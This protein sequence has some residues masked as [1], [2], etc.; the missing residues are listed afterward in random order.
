MLQVL[1]VVLLAEA[2]GVY[3]SWK[4]TRASVWNTV[5]RSLKPLFLLSSNPSPKFSFHSVD[6]SC[7]LL[8]TAEGGLLNQCSTSCFDVCNS[9]GPCGGVAPAVQMGQP[10]AKL[11]FS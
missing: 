2:G 6:G 3:S 7:P 10:E 5:S 4:L 9:E 8:N 11:K 1:A